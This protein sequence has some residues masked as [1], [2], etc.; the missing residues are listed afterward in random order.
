M[1][2]YEDTCPECGK[3]FT[4]YHEPRA[5]RLRCS[6]GC[7]LDAAHEVERHE[8]RAENA[9]LRAALEQIRD[10]LAGQSFPQMHEQAIVEFIDIALK[11][12]GR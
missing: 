5:N 7:D 6:V 4:N 8:L 1:S 2:A 12:G 10:R 11:E 9:R 3:T